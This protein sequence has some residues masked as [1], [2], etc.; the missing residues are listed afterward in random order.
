[1]AQKAA[2]QQAA[3]NAATLKRMHIASLVAHLA[4]LFLRLTLRRASTTWT[5]YTVYV[6]MSIPALSI[7]FWF[8]SIGTPTY[9]SNG[10][11]KRAGEDLEAKGLTEFLVD[12]FWWTNGVIIG[13]GLFGDRMWW[14][15]IVAPIYGIYLAVST[16]MGLRQGLAGMA[17]QGADDTVS[18]SNR[19]KKLEKRSGPKMQYR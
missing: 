3:R 14:F 7:E 1:M 2:K 8:Q 10:E 5:S 6:L 17:G 4:F 12:V 16:F 18:T 19:Q 15:L 13:A 9:D 11:L